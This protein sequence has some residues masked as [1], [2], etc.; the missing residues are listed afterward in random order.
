MWRF[1]QCAVAGRGH[2]RRGIPCQDKTYRFQ[3]N[4]VN[5]VALAD[6][7]GSAKLSHLG[8]SRIS[9]FTCKEMAE[10]FDCYYANENGEAVK[11]YLISLFLDELGNLAE[12]KDCSIDDLAST[13]LFVAEKNEKFIIGHIG[14]GVIGY[15][16]NNELKIASYPHN[17]EFTNTTM[18]VTSDG[19]EKTFR[20][21]KGSTHNGIDGFVLFSDGTESAFYD[22]KNKTLSKA[23]NR[24][25]NLI[26]FGNSNMIE[27]RITNFFSCDVRGRTL[28]DCSIAIMVDDHNKCFSNI[29][30]S[31][32]AEMLSLS[33]YLSD[34]KKKVNQYQRIIEMLKT[35]MELSLLSKMFCSKKRYMRK[36]I[37]KIST[38]KFSNYIRWEIYITVKMIGI[39]KNKNVYFCFRVYQKS[40]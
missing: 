24:I 35:P 1:F 36:K 14:D 27:V 18:F 28:D 9:E 40:K 33:P 7:A 26:R 29:N 23:L 3:Y 25:M 2:E 4:G 38:G 37:K 5:T 12:I 16:K 15:T 20:L 39:G 6:G 21:L 32:Q 11:K 17:G 8:A 19:V 30:P 31:V 13:I 10:H 22:K 34:T